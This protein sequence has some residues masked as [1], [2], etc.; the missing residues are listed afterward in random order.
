MRNTTTTVVI[1][2]GV[3]LAALSLPEQGTHPSRFAYLCMAAFPPPIQERP[4]SAR[5]LALCPPGDYWPQTPPT[6]YG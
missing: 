4:P 2:A 1:A 5:T 6:P 3:V